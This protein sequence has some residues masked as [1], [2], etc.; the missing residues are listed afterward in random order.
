MLLLQQLLLTN[1]SQIDGNW[2]K[3]GTSAWVGSIVVTDPTIP[4]LLVPNN[5]Y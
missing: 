3:V 2:V 4:L 5:G 1:Y